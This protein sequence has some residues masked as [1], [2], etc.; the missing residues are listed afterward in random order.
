[1][2]QR[3]KRLAAM[4]K[5]LALI[6]GTHKVGC[7]NRELSFDPIMYIVSV[8]LSIC[9]IWLSLRLSWMF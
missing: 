9:F 5:D 8:C 7:K 6:P 3:L 1:M 4:A 2:T